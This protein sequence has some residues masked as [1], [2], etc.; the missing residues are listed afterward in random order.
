MKTMFRFASFLSYLPSGFVPV[1]KGDKT[2]LREE[3][4]NLLQIKISPVSS[5]NPQTSK[6]VIMTSLY[7]KGERSFYI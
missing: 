4:T 5:Q 6:K 2:P 7:N 3:V 1:N